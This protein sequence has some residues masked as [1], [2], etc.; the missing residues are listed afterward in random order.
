MSDEAGWRDGKEIYAMFKSKDEAEKE[1]AAWKAF[2][3]D[4]STIETE[5]EGAG[6]DLKSVL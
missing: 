5:D 3:Q 4:L 2:W 1:E 6:D